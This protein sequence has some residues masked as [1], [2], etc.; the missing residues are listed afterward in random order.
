MTDPSDS[1]PPPQRRPPKLWSPLWIL[2]ALFFSLVLLLRVLPAVM[3]AL[4]ALASSVFRQVAALAGNPALGIATLLL[5][6]GLVALVLWG[7]RRRK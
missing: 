2:L 4:R 7:R 1:A 5:A 3:S 6:L